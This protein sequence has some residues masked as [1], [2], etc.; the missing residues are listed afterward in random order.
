MPDRSD[1]D[2]IIPRPV[3]DNS[4]WISSSS[5]LE[6]AENELLLIT[7]VTLL[8]AGVCVFL[9]LIIV[10]VLYLAFG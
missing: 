7:V 2:H 5:D 9:S 1:Y 8:G 4:I 3:V 6:H 10:V